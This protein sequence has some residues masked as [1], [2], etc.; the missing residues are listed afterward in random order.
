MLISDFPLTNSSGRILTNRIYRSK[1]KNN[2]L[3]IQKTFSYI[4]IVFETLKT[5][6]N[7][8]QGMKIFDVPRFT[9]LNESVDEHKHPKGHFIVCLTI[10]WLVNISSKE[11]RICPSRRSRKRSSICNLSRLDKWKLIHLVKVFFCTASRWSATFKTRRSA[12]SNAK[13]DMGFF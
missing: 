13:T 12:G 2:S 8:L 10:V 6:F 11:I 7:I 5:L 4:M 9:G 3:L 1:E